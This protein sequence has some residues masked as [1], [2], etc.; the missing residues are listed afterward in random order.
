MPSVTADAERPSGLTGILTS[1]RGAGAPRA[2]G[3]GAG[4]N[5]AGGGCG[6]EC[7]A[8]PCDRLPHDGDEL[9]A[10]TEGWERRRG[11][12]APA[13][14][15]ADREAKSPGLSWSGPWRLRAAL[16]HAAST[17][18]SHSQL[19]PVAS[20]AEAAL[21]QHVLA[22]A[23]SRRK[24]LICEASKELRHQLANARCC[25][26]LSCNSAASQ[27][28]RTTPA[29]LRHCCCPRRRQSATTAS[30]DQ[31]DQTWTSRSMLAS[32]AFAQGRCSRH[33]C[34]KCMGPTLMPREAATLAFLLTVFASSVTPLTAGSGSGP[35]SACEVPPVLCGA[36]I[37]RQEWKARHTATRV[38]FR[39][40]SMLSILLPHSRSDVEV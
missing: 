27:A 30:R 16:T 2:T 9:R 10:A 35:S 29:W 33:E 6:S 26:N 11:D 1:R 14:E 32:G 25:T 23:L 19:E 13:A 7:A 24:I 36:A 37:F 3:L 31:A 40:A 22:R 15:T 4:R 38:W 39:S 28:Y 18:R 21:R 34:A 5:A 8:A 17:V 20:L 12:S